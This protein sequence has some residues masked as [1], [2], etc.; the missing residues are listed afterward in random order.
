M[1]TKGVAALLLTVSLTAC[2]GKGSDDT[3]S[4]MRTSGTSGTSESTPGKAPTSGPKLPAC[5][6]IWQADATLPADY[7]GCALDGETRLEQS[8][9]C[10]DDTHLIVHDEQFYAVTGEKVIEPKAAPLEDSPAFG[11]AFVACTGS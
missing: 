7:A 5:G 4:D 10:K 2:G 1:L 11:K 9:K 8:T 3:S 6:D